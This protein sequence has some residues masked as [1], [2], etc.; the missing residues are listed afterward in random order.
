MLTALQNDLFDD[1]QAPKHP[2]NDNNPWP[3]FFWAYHDKHPEVYEVFKRFTFDV[4][5]TGIKHYASAA[6]VHR[7]RWWSEIERDDLEPFKIDQRL[8]TYYGRMFMRDYPEH[9]G[10]FRTRKTRMV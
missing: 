3:E 7:M 1:E 8:C 10:F 2:A 9:A 5:A 6:I 4:I